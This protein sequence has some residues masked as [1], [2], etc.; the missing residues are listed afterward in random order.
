MNITN[1]AD[2]SQMSLPDSSSSPLKVALVY[3]TSKINTQ[4]QP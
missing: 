3:I 4:H 1:L 2:S